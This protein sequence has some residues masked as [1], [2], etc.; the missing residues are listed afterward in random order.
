[1]NQII[2][3]IKN[4]LIFKIWQRNIYKWVKKTN[5]RWFK[6]KKRIKESFKN[7]FNNKENFFWWKIKKMKKKK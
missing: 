5:I 1:M 6:R 3:K 2:Q 7:Q 4:F